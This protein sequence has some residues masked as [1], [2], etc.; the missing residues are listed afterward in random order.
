MRLRVRYFALGAAVMVVGLAVH[1]R[2]PSLPAD[3]RDVIGD[4]LWATM[5]AS[6]VSAIFPSQRAW[7]RYATAL[8]VC[9]AVEFS[10]LSQLAALRHVRSTLLGRLALG[11][12]FDPRD[13]A[14]YA[15]GILIFIALDRRWFLAR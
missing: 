9:Y 3:A 1:L 15:L 11:S 10:Q 2:G 12:G 4:A 8:A 6:F 5:M 13:F 14:A 7:Q